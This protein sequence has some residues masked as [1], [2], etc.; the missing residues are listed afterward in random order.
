[1][2]AYEFPPDLGGVETYS[3]GLAGA[4]AEAGIEVTLY[5]RRD[6]PSLPCP[7]GTRRKA[8]LS[9]RRQ[10]DLPLLRAESVDVWHPTNA[11]YAW[12][13]LE[14][15]RPVVVS[16]H[17]ND[18]LKP[19]ILSERH[20]LSSVPVLWR[21]KSPLHRMLRPRARKAT[22]RLLS[23]ALPRCRCILANSRYTESVLLE[24]I[25]T[26]RGLTRVAGVG[27]SD[28]FL[29]WSPP[30][31]LER[32]P[33]QLITIARLSEP[34]KNVDLVLRSLAKLGDLYDWR[35]NV[36]GEGP[37]RRR[38]EALAHELGIAGR[39]RFLG[40]VDD[41]TLRVEL[42]SAGLMVLV[43]SVLPG[44]HEGFGIVYLEAN[45]CGTPVL[46]ARVGGAVEAVNEGH[47]GFFLERL[48]EEALGEALRSHLGGQRR[49]DEAEC[50][51]WAENFRW[52]R[53]AETAIASYSAE[54]GCA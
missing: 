12:L 4:L 8:V 37:D 10:T 17:G 41:E 2:V 42:A 50:R 32:Q 14:D 47:S 36:I 39:V 45:A 53:V 26:C 5:T 16:V 7:P 13:A 38:L 18:F 6:R 27:V 22:L 19:Y 35:Y 43:S 23:R 9:G 21:W 52:S 48:D 3:W 46:A 34:R 24:K 30:A 51:G 20:D 49:F 15:S 25:P 31:G 44:S 11:A 1:M 33:N 54:A 29:S 40:S 28:K